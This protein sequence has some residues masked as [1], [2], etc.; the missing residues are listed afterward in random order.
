LRRAA[1]PRDPALTGTREPARTPR[2]SGNVLRRSL[3][4]P[5]GN[6]ESSFNE[7]EGRA[8]YWCHQIYWIRSGARLHLR[9]A[10]CARRNASVLRSQ[11]SA[12]SIL[13]WLQLRRAH[14][15]VRDRARAQT[16]ISSASFPGLSRFRALLRSAVAGP[17]VR[18]RYCASNDRVKLSAVGADV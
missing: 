1:S 11:P 16:C 17:A 14:L 8:L 3:A 10:L 15:R 12:P 13:R 18:R 6:R 5:L 7:P 4:A 9:A 2:E